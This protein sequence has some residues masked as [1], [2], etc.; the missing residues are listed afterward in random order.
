M[1]SPPCSSIHPP[2]PVPS[3]LLHPPPAQ[4]CT[5]TASII[6][7]LAHL[8]IR[9]F[10]CPALHHF[11]I[12]SIM[13]LVAHCADSGSSATAA[14]GQHYR[15]AEANDEL[16]PLAKKIPKPRLGKDLQDNNKKILQRN[17]LVKIVDWLER[18]PEKIVD[19]WAA[20][21]ADLVKDK[22]VVDKDGPWNKDYRHIWRLPDYWKAQFLQKRC[23]DVFTTA[24]LKSLEEMD[25]NN[26]KNLFSMEVGLDPHDP[27]PRPCL[28]KEVCYRTF[29]A[30]AEMLGG[31]LR[32]L[33]PGSIR[34]GC[35]L[36]WSEIGVF[37]LHFTDKKC[38]LLEHVSGA[39]G[40]LPEHIMITTAFVLIDNHSDMKAKVKCGKLE[41]YLKDFFDDGAGPH[42][43]PIGNKGA[44]L[45]A[46]AK[47]QED[48]Q[49]KEYA[50]AAQT[51]LVPQPDLLG[52]GRKEEQRKRALEKARERMNEVKKRKL[53]A[54]E[55][56]LK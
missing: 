47:E 45:V 3:P 23:P 25:D 55:T 6:A 10:W 22:K 20:I 17:A 30:R 33:P 53:E 37:T 50:V 46:L 38:V 51:K 5:S 40:T 44:A 56:K 21:Q 54:K 12:D 31:R 48:K 28:D 14:F 36:D 4:A 34:P 29:N 16:S 42:A 49:Q 43:N 8:M 2:P 9:A 41:F 24:T 7:I 35:K 32:S 15:A 13:A 18:N 52:D 39:E 1:S 19:T 26:I 27:L 11:R